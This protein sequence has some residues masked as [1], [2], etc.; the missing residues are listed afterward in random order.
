MLNQSVGENAGRIWK[1]LNEKGPLVVSGIKKATGLDDKNT[2]MAIG[3]LA[4]EGK[5]K[6]ENKQGLMF[7]SLSGS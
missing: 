7:M 6:F 1:V 3:W 5:L 2:Y 4:K